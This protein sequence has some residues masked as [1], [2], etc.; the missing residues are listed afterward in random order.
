L[1]TK[2]KFRVIILNRMKT[3]IEKRRPIIYIEIKEILKKEI[4]SGR[5][6]LLSE[7]KIIHQF[8]VSSTT[9]RRVLNDLEEEGVNPC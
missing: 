4:L 9:A 2:I 1:L 3:R 8:K 6:N 7:S 5:L